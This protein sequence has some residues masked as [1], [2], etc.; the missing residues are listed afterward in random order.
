MH[1]SIKTKIALASVSIIVLVSAFIWNLMQ[2]QEEITR[3]MQDMISNNM[4]AM[5]S[6]QLIKYNVALYDNLTFRYLTTKNPRLLEEKAAARDTVLQWIMQMQSLSQTETEK[7]LLVQIRQEM[8]EY[9]GEN[10]ALMSTYKSKP[11]EVAPAGKGMIGKL[12]QAITGPSKADT[13]K[14]ELKI[15]KREQKISTISREGQTRLNTIFYLC[16]KLVDIARVKLEESEKSM[17]DTLL[18]TQMSALTS[19]AAVL[20]AVS[21]VGFILSFNISKPLQNLLQGV[22]KVTSGQLNVELPVESGDEIGYLTHEF[23][24]MI[25]KLKEN[26]ERLVTETITDSLT[27]LYNLRYFQNQIKNEITRSHR[28]KHTFV[29]LILD[30]DHFKKFND[31]NGHPL[32]NVLLKQMANMLKE[33]LRQDSL[34]AR[35]GGEEFV[36]ILSETPPEGGKAVAERLR[37]Q[38]EQAVFPGQDKMPEERITVS[39]GGATFPKDASMAEQLIEKADKALYAA[40]NAGRNRVQWS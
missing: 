4:A 21:V 36:I 11:P 9:E 33:A 27:G 32:G 19:G 7:D 12:K 29:L 39:I 2:T 24:T 25:A 1:L 18:A 10:K 20:L 17:Q 13:A 16:D 28:Y 34:V 14:Q 31:A 5:R 37:K 30:I 3:R 8:S 26:Q 6:A 23:N 22:R 38:I 40:K 35:Y 15:E